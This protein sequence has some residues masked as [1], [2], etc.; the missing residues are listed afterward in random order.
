MIDA[1]ER[2]ML[3]RISRTRILWLRCIEAVIPFQIKVA[4]FAAC[5]IVLVIKEVANN[6]VMREDSEGG[7]GLV[8][9]SYI[10]L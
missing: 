7:V 5:E 10:A 8:P 4:F 1:K 9:S 2:N 3:N 6:L